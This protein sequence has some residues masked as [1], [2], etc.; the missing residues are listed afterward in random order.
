MILPGFTRRENPFN[1][2]NYQFTL[3]HRF[4]I[5]GPPLCSGD[6]NRDGKLDFYI[7]GSSR[8]PGA[9]LLSAGEG[10][11]LRYLPSDQSTAKIQE[12]TAAAFF[13]ADRDGDLDLIC[14]AGG[15][16]FLDKEAYHDLLY[17]NNGDGTFTNAEIR[18]PGRNGPGSSLA[19]TDYDHDGDDDLFIG[20]DMQP[21]RYPLATASVLLRNDAHP[22]AHTI[23][24]TDMTDTWASGLRKA[25]MVR[26][27]VWKDFNGDG[28]EDLLVAG[29][30]MPLRFW[31]KSVE[32][33][34]QPADPAAMKYSAGWYRSLLVDDFDGDGDPDIVAGNQGLNSGYRASEQEPLTVRYRDFD[35]DGRMDAFLYQY[36]MGKEYPV[37]TR[38][39]YVEQIAGLRKR[40]YYFRDFGGMGYHEIFSEA[41]RSGVDSLQVYQLASVYLENLGAGR[42]SLRPLPR[43]VQTSV[44]MDMQSADVNMDGKQDILAVGNNYAPEALSG[45]MDAG[46]G[47]V[48]VGDGKGNFRSIPYRES[49]FFVRGDTRKLALLRHAGTQI[50]LV[51]S[52][53]GPLQCF[54]LLPGNGE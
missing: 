6:V 13:D 1:D 51:A 14:I 44:V 50:V 33:K 27:A 17:L 30:F 23:G 37:Q 34:L 29:E 52:N 38:T 19:L 5:Q 7:G 9:M 41:E 24:F 40:I 15:N 43:D 45:R 53:E 20:G 46:N 12:E 8:Q 49:G 3:P 18:L 25:G 22:Q 26:D 39:Q 2:F 4:S 48:L 47:W 54:R 42:F 32:G 21:Q 11:Q 16:E 10:Y 31:W 35:G 36:R 28:R